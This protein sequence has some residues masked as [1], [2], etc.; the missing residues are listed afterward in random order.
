MIYKN[1]RF[2]Y[3]YCIGPHRLFSIFR[4][5]N[6]KLS[7]SGLITYTKNSI[8]DDRS[9]FK[10]APEKN[11]TFKTKPRR[12][13]SLR[14]LQRVE[15]LVLKLCWFYLKKTEL[16][17]DPYFL[18]AFFL[19]KQRV[20]PLVQAIASLEFFNTSVPILTVITSLPQH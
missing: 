11:E 12:S 2:F 18:F 3:F 13:K 16:K 20:H 6:E 14:L 15:F 17:S 4:R 8:I 1:S 5:Q 9:G 19:E 7:Q 10:E